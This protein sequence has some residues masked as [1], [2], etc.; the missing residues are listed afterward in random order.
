MGV[1]EQASRKVSTQVQ[2]DLDLTLP[3]QVPS[4]SSF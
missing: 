3:G 1:G 4:L 2:S